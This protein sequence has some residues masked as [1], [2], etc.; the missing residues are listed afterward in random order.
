MGYTHYWDT[1]RR[2]TDE[3]WK[4]IQTN[5]RKILRVAQE[6]WGIALSEEFD[7]NR[8][9]I[10]DA[11]QIRFNGYADEGHETFLITRAP[12]EFSFCKT[13]N[14]EYDAPVIAILMYIMHV[15]LDAFSW[16]SDGWLSEHADGLKLL[17]Q[18]CGIDLEWS[19]VEVSDN[20]PDRAK[21]TNVIDLEFEKDKRA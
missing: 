14:K 13:A 5:A 3:E 8:T 6:D 20:D 18:A 12:T 4:A 7:I 15:A 9:P 1:S 21:V 11:D 19:N 10:V 17:K 2:F 16:R